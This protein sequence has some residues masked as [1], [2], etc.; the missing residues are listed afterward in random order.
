MCQNPFF[1][2]SSPRFPSH[3]PIFSPLYFST[4]LDF[5][6]ASRRLSASIV[7][8]RAAF[9]AT[10][11]WVESVVF[12]NLK[13]QDQRHR[14]WL[15]EQP[16][17]DHEIAQESGARLVEQEGALQK[18]LSPKERLPNITFLSIYKTNI[19][20][21]VW[22]V[23]EHK[24]VPHQHTDVWPPTADLLGSRTTGPDSSSGFLFFSED[25]RIILQPAQIPSGMLPSIHPRRRLWQWYEDEMWIAMQR[26]LWN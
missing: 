25:I 18:K 8:K 11:F 15:T 10:Q 26:S 1:F 12:Y 20:F 17:R 4:R 2:V 6:G 23:R 13:C 3:Y 21:S 22:Y 7:L 24:I 9:H 14:R 19:N 5:S 16:A